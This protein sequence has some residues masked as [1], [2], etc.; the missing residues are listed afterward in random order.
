MAEFVEKTLRM[1]GEW[2]NIEILEMNV[3]EDHIPMILFMPL[4]IIHIRSNRNA[5]R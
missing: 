4:K 5:I 3:K 2:R 1:L